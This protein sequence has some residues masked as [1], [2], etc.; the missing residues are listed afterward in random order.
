MAL[1]RRTREEILSPQSK[2]E[3]KTEKTE[4]A[5][6]VPA[7]G[8]NGAEDPRP[9][10][11]SAAEETL[12]DSASPVA[13]ITAHIL[14]QLETAWR[15][16]ENFIFRHYP[17]DGAYLKGLKQIEIPHFEIPEVVIAQLS[18]VSGGKS[19]FVN[20]NICHYP[21]CPVATTTTSIC[22]VETRRAPTPQDERIEVCLLTPKKDE[23]EKQPVR[24]FRKQVLDELLFKK[25]FGYA[26]FLGEENILKISDTLAF[27]EDDEGEIAMTPHNWRHC[28]VLLMVVLDAYIFQD[29]RNSP[30][31]GQNYKE[32]N[33]MRDELLHLLG[34]PAGQD[35]GLRLYWCSE[36][37]PEHAVIVDLP[38]LGAATETVNGQLSHTE[39]VCKYI[40]EKASALLFFTDESATIT[41]PD[42]RNML[43][44]FLAANSGKGDS[45]VRFTIVV[46]KADM[47]DMAAK[48]ER[49]VM[50]GKKDFREI[51]D[52]SIQTSISNFRTSFPAYGA[53]P[54]YALS[55]YNGEWLMQEGG[56]PLHNLHH[57]AD[58]IS[59]CVRFGRAPTTQEVC[60]EQ[61]KYFDRAYPCQARIGA[62]FSA[63]SVGTFVQTFVTDY[64]GQ[65]QFLTALEHLNKQIDS[66]T[67]MAG[68]IALERELFNSAR[69]FSP[70]LA[71]I[72]SDAICRAMNQAVDNLNN[73]FSKLNADMNKMMTAAV[74][75][76]DGITN[77]FDAD[78]HV[79]NGVINGKLQE[80]FSALRKNS[81]GTI[82]ITPNAFGGNTDGSNNRR[83]ILDLAD[84]IASIPFIG[85]FS[86]SFSMLHKEFDNE[87]KFY[88][89]VVKSIS[90]ILQK[91]PK[92]ALEEMDKQFQFA[93]EKKNLLGVPGFDRALK[94]AKTSTQ[95]LLVTVCD[96]Y[97]K[98]V[99]ADTRV[100]E[101][102]NQT[103]NRIQLDLMRILSPYTKS[104]YGADILNKIRKSHFFAADTINPDKL[105]ELLT[106]HYISDF[107]K[108]M[109]STLKNDLSGT[110]NIDD[111]HLI[112]VQNALNDFFKKRL[113]QAALASLST[114]VQ[115]ACSVTEGLLQDPGMLSA[116]NSGLTNAEKDLGIFIADGTVYHYFI[117]IADPMAALEWAG[118]AVVV[119]QEKAEEMRASIEA[120]IE[121]SEL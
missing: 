115:S 111:S 11:I 83:E 43:D 49:S 104:G 36:D 63:M 116:W 37:I 22:A 89:G 71:C 17:P 77:Q 87:R 27:F 39:L 35:Y 4:D 69:R 80:K 7:A 114:Q 96:T 10:Q 18:D 24:I 14:K 56:I 15:R 47:A 58:F 107:K 34:V 38:G 31:T 67:T 112:R 42:V 16:E 62:P 70:E 81:N 21:I 51:A 119:S 101:T 73:Q 94:L 5:V 75:R 91:F 121:R 100:K 102:L 120:N 3:K 74:G 61:K 52:N 76:I 85:Y 48:K 25:L 1:H 88:E 54:V 113:S 23:L 19:S 59:D 9:A 29:K 65:I 92:Q 66:I 2:P 13:D 26:K 99:Q 20:S 93:L 117:G 60:E 118:A 78:Y 97:A 53:Y 79:L 105:K 72:V 40:M 28:M 109:E 106:Q 103:M 33:I 84:K 95:K 6:S 30:D 8:Q 44:S 32:A 68:A 45:S 57:A 82:P 98:G 110:I 90:E 86:T 64:V 50:L 55:S 41:S 108:Q 12:P 46:N